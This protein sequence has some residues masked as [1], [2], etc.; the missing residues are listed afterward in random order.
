VALSHARGWTS[1]APDAVAD[2]AGPGPRSGF[3][4]DVEGL[5]AVA[6]LLVV[7]YH[8]GIAFLP[9]GFVGV[10]VFFVIS[11]FLITGLLVRELDATGRI[12]IPRF[13][14]RRVRRLLPAIVVMTVVIAILAWFVQNPLDREDTGGDIVAAGLFYANWHFAQ[15]AVDYLASQQEPS[16]FLHMWSLSVEEQFY[17]V[18]PMLLVGLTALGTRLAGRDGQRRS[19]DPR[20]IRR[21]LFDDGR[22]GSGPAEPPADRTSVNPPATEQA[23]VSPRNRARTGLVLLAG[24]GLV[25]LLSLLLSWWL[26]PRDAGLAYFDS[27]TRAWE[28][29]LG[30]ALALLTPQLRRL[31]RVAAA[32]LGWLGLLAV[33]VSGVV[34]TGDMPFPGLVALVPTLGAGALLAAGAALPTSGASRLLSVRPMQQMGQASYGWYLWHWPLLV[35]AAVWLG[36]DLSTV[37]GIVVVALAYGLAVLSLRLVENPVRHSVALLRHTRRT[38]LIGLACTAVVVGTG[39][40]LRY[41]T[42]ARTLP[43]GQA[44]GAAALAPAR[45]SA[46]SNHADSSALPPP[47]PLQRSASAVAPDP[48]VARDD[49]PVLYSDGCHRSYSS[50][51]A[52][53]CVFGDPNGALSVFLFG[54]SHAAQWFPALN[55]LANKYHW[56]LTAMTKSGCPAASMEPYNSVI[57]GPYAACPVWRANVLAR[58]AREHPQLVFTVSINGYAWAQGG[59]RVVGPPATQAQTQGWLTTLRALARSAGSVVLMRDTP[60]MG[61]DV[62][63]CVSAN[64][65]DLLTCATP[66]SV[67]ITANQSDEQAQDIL[68]ALPH[69][70]YLDMNDY[71]CP[72]RV[73]PA[74]IGNVLVYRDKD[75]LTATY[76]TTLAPIL[77]QRLQPFLP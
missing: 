18:W 8:A 35:L 15:Q 53:G 42:P 38:L 55:L 27:F 21:R 24:V 46:P 44:L 70:H 11:G 73:C 33:V 30:A 16:P 68:G 34:I 65:S 12:S 23:R 66:R 49:L 67:A 31:P 6:I 64:M 17:L 76:M 25:I 4:A 7:A 26:T 74:V 48:S 59:Q 51:S 54:D 13:Y 61:R 22:A 40:V 3:R 10:D 36:R 9:G 71:V 28:L 5:R 72:G 43:P 29:A 69:L 58:I 75:H 60:D 41:A 50:T 14:A 62:A 45:P 52:S 32:L 1:R 37:E 63:G 56:R 57:K 2:R 20:S 47:P 19:F 39:L 77:Y